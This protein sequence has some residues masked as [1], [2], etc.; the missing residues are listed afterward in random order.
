MVSDI[1]GFSIKKPR[2]RAGQN[3]KRSAT[4]NIWSTV[5]AM[6]SESENENPPR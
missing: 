5:A 6:I 2:T 3:V 1:Q 4:S